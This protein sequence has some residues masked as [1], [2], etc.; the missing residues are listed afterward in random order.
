MRL[1]VRLVVEN[2][3]GE[4]QGQPVLAIAHL[5]GGHE[6]QRVVR[7][8]GDPFQVSVQVVEVHLADIAQT[9]SP[10]VVDRA[11]DQL[12]GFFGLQVQHFFSSRRARSGVV[13]RPSVSPDPGGAPVEKTS[14]RI[15][16]RARTGL[17]FCAGPVTH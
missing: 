7:G 14:P 10:G 1:D 6:S 4:G 16:T 9:F 13:T 3:L 17:A 5:G 2:V 15:L 8:E 11:S 12:T